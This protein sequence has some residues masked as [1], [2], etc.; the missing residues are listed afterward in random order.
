MND[1]MYEGREEEEGRGR[2]VDGGDEEDGMS[3]GQEASCQGMSE[4]IKDG[5]EK[6]FS[7]I[8][9]EGASQLARLSSAGHYSSFSRSVSDSQHK[10]LH[11][12]AAPCACE[13]MRVHVEAQ[14]GAASTGQNPGELQ[15]A[16]G[17]ASTDW[18]VSVRQ[19]ARARAFPGRLVLIQSD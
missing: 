15:E 10:S 19:R 12:K 13:R 14:H 4:K 11:S 5:G 16:A 17:P 9:G 3:V 18:H 2:V 1:Y 6:T 7:F 8:A